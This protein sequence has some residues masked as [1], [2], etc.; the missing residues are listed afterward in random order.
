MTPKITR[1]QFLAGTIAAGAAVYAP[2]LLADPGRRLKSLTDRVK[3]GGTGIEVSYLGF[4]TGTKGWDKR[5]NQTKLGTVKFARMINHAYDQG[6]NYFD[7]ADIYGT[8]QYLRASLRRIPRENYVLETKIWFRTT[9][10][11][12]KDLDRFLGELN[13][14]YIDILYIHCVTEANWATDLREIEDVLEAA[15]QKKI[16]RAHG[17]SIHDLDVMKGAV[18]NP[19][20][21]QCLCRI[22]PFGTMMDGPAA[23]VVPVLRKLHDAGKGVTGIKI[24]GEGKIADKREESL[25][26][27]LGLD[28][29]DAV[30]IGFESPAQ[31]DDII[32]MGNKALAL[33]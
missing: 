14:D 32:R 23:D 9:E 29:V 2:E 15:K 20:V 13:T 1:R 28:C 7:C 4:G 6:V 26:F 8:H 21:D 22:N 11:A 30:V 10:G 18:E 3:L 25:R 19:W 27:V 24:L 31:V 5:S 16:I 33:K 12:Q 17:I